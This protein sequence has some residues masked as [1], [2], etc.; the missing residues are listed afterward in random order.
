MERKHA[1]RWFP[2]PPRLCKPRGKAGGGVQGQRW[3]DPE[4][5]AAMTLQECLESI[6]SFL[7][8]MRENRPRMEWHLPEVTQ[9]VGDKTG[10]GSKLPTSQVPFF[11]LRQSLLPLVF[12]LAFSCCSPGNTRLGISLVPYGLCEMKSRTFLESL[13]SQG[14]DSGSHHFFVV[15]LGTTR[16]VQTT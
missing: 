14:F 10:V 2:I 13:T 1:G 5:Q 15:F 8:I 4:P 11:P 3:E 6:S 16:F 12:A 7:Q 9:K